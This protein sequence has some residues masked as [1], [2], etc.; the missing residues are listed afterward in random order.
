MIG[1]DVLLFISLP[2]R[3]GQ[4]RFACNCCFRHAPSPVVF[5]GYSATNC[6]PSAYSLLCHTNGPLYNDS[7]RHFLITQQTRCYSVRSKKPR[8][9][10]GH[11]GK[12][13][14]FLFWTLELQGQLLCS[15]SFHS[16]RSLHGSSGWPCGISGGSG[17]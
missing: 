10:W 4:H 17:Q 13:H 11:R 1:C 15:S 2:P 3:Q 14:T 7:C 5:I 6:K 16:A 8:N 9:V 12:S